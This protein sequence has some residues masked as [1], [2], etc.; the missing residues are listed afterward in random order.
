MSDQIGRFLV[1]M[2]AIIEN[3]NTGKILLL[4]RGIQKDF[5]PDIWEYPTGR[6]NQ[7][8][9]PLNGLR[10]EVFEETGL[11]VDI[12]KP[13]NIFHFFRG[14]QIAE[15]ELVGIMYWCQASVEAV[16]VSEEHSDY[17]WVTVE[18]AL[19]LVT[20][21]SMQADIQAFIKEKAI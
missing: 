19:K 18:E 15:K 14:E 13:I 21:P 2:G 12:I 6:L 20:K 5:S 4:K 9:E 1:A 8:E 16:V 7:F 11:E 17:Q 10:R 3:K